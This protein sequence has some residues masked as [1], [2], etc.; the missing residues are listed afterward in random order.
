[1]AD[2]ADER[3][4]QRLNALKPSTVQIQ[5]EKYVAACYALCKN[6]S[7]DTQRPGNRSTLTLSLQHCSRRLVLGP[8]M[9]VLTALRDLL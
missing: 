8:C 5:R 2:D 9:E 4:L 1:M 3:L 7:S 6:P